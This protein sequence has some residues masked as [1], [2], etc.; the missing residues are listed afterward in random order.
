MTACV[1][2]QRNVR[3]T[4]GILTII[5]AVCTAAGTSRAAAVEAL[6]RSTTPIRL[7]DAVRG[8]CLEILKSALQDNEFWPAMHAAEGLTS[9]GCADQ[10]R[11][12]LNARLKTEEDDQHRCGLARE[13]VRAGDLSKVVI[14]LE[15]LA[16]PNPY[17]HTHA[18]ESLFKCFRTGDGRG[19]RA[20]LHQADKPTLQIMAAAALG[21]CGSPEAMALLR[22][23]LNDQDV[24][25]QRIAAWVL[26][27]IGD[28][29]DIPPVRRNV[30]ATTDRLAKAFGEHALAQLGDAQGRQALLENLR[31]DDA[32][33]RTYAANFAGE[34]RMGEAADSLIPLLDDAVLDV[35]VRAAH[36]LLTLAQAVSPTDASVFQREVYVATKQHPRYSEGSILELNDGTLLYAVTEFVGSGADAAT[37]QI[38]GRSSTDGGRTWGE[39]RLLQENVGRQNVMSVTLR[40]L[41]PAVNGPAPIG[42]F[43]LVKNGPDS[44]EV[45]LRISTDEAQTFAPPILVTDRPGY[46]VM[47]NDRVTVLTSGRLL[48]PI[49]ATAAL[50]LDKF[51]SYCCL[52]DDGGHTWRYGQGRVELPKRGAME[53]EVVELRDGRVLMIIRN[54]LGTISTAWSEDGGDT[55]SSPGE[56]PGIRA[57]ESPATLR[58]I[59]ATGDLLLVW[60]NNY[61]TGAGHG[62]K[63]TPLTAAISRDD[64]QTWEN[65]R[66]LDAQANEQYAYTSLI[67]VQDRALLSYYVA[68]GRTGLLSSRFRSVPVRW[69]YSQPDPD[70]T[71]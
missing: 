22:D 65:I 42:M 3:V 30:D 54:Q 39:P 64:G 26:G 1:A 71:R 15:I 66:N 48:A 67:F 13:L 4:I 6:S 45:H 46:H 62:G 50:R 36:S 7:A 24:E 69:F 31:S 47:N 11:D 18:C 25:V 10:V 60:N 8:R 16:K 43:Y 2:A 59:P 23:K 44:L 55:W 28:A 49:A 37:A 51:V 40:R 21:R 58:R 33:I 34:A 32:A 27:A 63:R 19:L 53:P 57:P 52:S 61:E 20:A 12:S 9:A 17:G 56:L 38:M 70:P 5:L 14:M 29:S 41:S 35:R 68:D